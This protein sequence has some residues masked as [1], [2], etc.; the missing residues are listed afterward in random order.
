MSAISRKQMVFT[1]PYKLA[2]RFS[3]AQT[4]FE[5]HTPENVYHTEANKRMQQ[6]S[7]LWRTY[8]QSRR[9]IVTHEQRY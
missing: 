5:V 4:P 2:V 9:Q 6:R 3:Y 7:K 1:L 8:N